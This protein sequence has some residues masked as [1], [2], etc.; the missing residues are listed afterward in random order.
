MSCI[1]TKAELARLAAVSR[2]AVRKAETQGKIQPTAEGKL[3]LAERKNLAFLRRAL[4]RKA[5]DMAM[6]T[7]K[8]LPGWAALCAEKSNGGLFPLVFF[9]PYP[10]ADDDAIDLQRGWEIDQER[11]TAKDPKGGEHPLQ[12][13]YDYQNPPPWLEV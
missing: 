11:W 12:L 13:R 1:I 10:L 6:N 3:D 9:Q 7:R 4:D 2:A 5:A 8:I